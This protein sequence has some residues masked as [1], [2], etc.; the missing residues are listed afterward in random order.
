MGSCKEIIM[1]K[2]QL[3]N[4]KV[5]G[6][7]ETLRF[8][9]SLY[10]NHKKI[11]NVSNEGTGGCHRY[12]FLSHDSSA[13]LQAAIAE[14]Q[15]ATLGPSDRFHYHLSNLLSMIS[16]ACP[17]F[18]LANIEPDEAINSLIAEIDEQRW[19]KL[20]RKNKTLFQIAGENRWKEIDAPDSDGVRRFVA[21]K[22][23]SVVFGNDL[24]KSKTK[25]RKALP[26][27]G[28]AWE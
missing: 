14:L 24:I 23:G 2:I 1:Q 3:K 7:E 11:A 28:S 8:E 13:K 5:T 17:E 21:S 18:S 20:K 25:L 27:K 10:L 9:D 4:L 12:T 26:S 19:L 22:Y 6:G 15:S 16:E